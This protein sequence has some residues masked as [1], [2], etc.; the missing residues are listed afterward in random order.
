MALSTLFFSTQKGLIM[1]YVLLEDE[2]DSDTAMVFWN[3][4]HLDVYL[5]DAAAEGD[6]GHFRIY[7]ID[8]R[9]KYTP[10]VSIT[11]ELQ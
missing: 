5:S 7:Q 9:D 11:V 1:M 10:K 6:I 8:P 2:D 4:E 3:K